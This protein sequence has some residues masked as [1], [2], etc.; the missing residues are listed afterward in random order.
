MT[1]LDDHGPFLRVEEAAR[2][3]RISRTVA[4]ALGASLA[5]NRWPRRLVDRSTASGSTVRAVAGF[6]AT[7][8]APK[9]LPAC[10]GR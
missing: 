3:L 8:S 7:F 1:M 9:K 6:D 10:G 4:Y 5:R 2:M